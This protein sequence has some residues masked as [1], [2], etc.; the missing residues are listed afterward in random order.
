M[1]T[2]R[3]AALLLV[4]LVLASAPSC[5]DGTTSADYGSFP[6]STV[7]DC[8]GSDV[9]MLD[10]I[11]QYDITYITFGAKWCTARKEEIPDINNNIVPKVDGSRVK[12]IQLL[13]ENNAG[14]APTAGLC[15]EWVDGFGPTFEVL[16]DID[17]TVVQAYY[18]GSV[19]STLPDH[20]LIDKTGKIVF[21]K[22]GKLPGN[23]DE[24]INGWL[25]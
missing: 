9:S 2:H 14:Q 15:Q 24:I 6:A 25:H 4:T 8:A 3:T 5:D 21:S 7:K 12:I 23:T 17:Q 18:G 11:G 16:S 13:L 10:L 1:K 22:Q 20:I 19:P